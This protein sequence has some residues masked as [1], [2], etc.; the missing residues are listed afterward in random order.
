MIQYVNKAITI[1]NWGKHQNLDKIEAN[2]AYMRE[3]MREYRKK[4]KEI[5][6]GKS[7]DKVNRKVNINSAD[8]DKESDKDK[9]SDKNIDNT[10][11]S[12]CDNEQPPLD[13]Q[14]IIN[15]FHST[16]KSL[17]GII[18]LT[19]KRKKAILSVREI[20]DGLSFE[21]F[22]EKIEDSDFL[23]GRN[24]EWR[25]DFDWITETKNVIKILEGKY[26]NRK[27][28]SKKDYSDCTK[29]ENMEMEI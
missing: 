17:P 1:T 8:K 7:E 4:Q 16:C 23:T 2:N 10:I 19:D 24:G 20:L 28:K 27:G 14:A 5:A 12:N 22:F 6:I 13:Y 9:N 25:C 29:Y 21:Q 11:L 18:K 15:S 26:D 3:Y